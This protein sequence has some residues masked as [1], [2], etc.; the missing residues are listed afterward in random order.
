MTL[1]FI[2]HVNRHMEVLREKELVCVL[3]VY[4]VVNVFYPRNKRTQ[5]LKVVRIRIYTYGLECVCWN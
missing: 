2:L 3:I 1:A 5:Y 4:I